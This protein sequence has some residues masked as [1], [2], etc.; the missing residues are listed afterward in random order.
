VV[1]GVGV[2]KVVADVVGFVASVV[3][4]DTVVV[5]VLGGVASV[6]CGATVHD[7]YCMQLWWA[8]LTQE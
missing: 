3:G 6:V 8:V 5:D 7:G 4:V 2:N 1:G